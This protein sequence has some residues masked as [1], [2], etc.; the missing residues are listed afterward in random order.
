MTT[1]L[2]ASLYAVKFAGGTPNDFVNSLADATQLPVVMSQ[3]DPKTLAPAEFETSGVDEISRAIRSQLKLLIY[4]GTD[5]VIGDQKLSR[6]LVSENNVQRF[7]GENVQGELTFRVN[8]EESVSGAGGATARAP[9]ASLPINGI[10]LPPTAIKEGKISFKT[11][12]MDAL[13]LNLIGSTLSKPVRT[14]WIYNEA[15]VF[16]NVKDVAEFDLMKL[17]AK[18]VGARLVSNQKEYFF[19]LDPVEIKKRAVATL[20]A[21]ATSSTASRRNNADTQAPAR[22]FRISVINALSPAQLSAALAETGSTAKFDLDSRSPLTR[23]AVQRVQQIDAERQNRPQNGPGG[24]Q[25]AIMSRIDNSRM[26]TL[27]VDSRFGVRM[28]IPILDQNGR[29]GGVVRL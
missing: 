6:N 14:H 18:A 10:P 24:G 17:V 4:P 28:E 25:P 3:G 13:Q 5:L 16:L 26:A 21:E 1:L 11:E 19:D 29:P 9:Q 7:R 8:F 23:L 27:S 12:K 2:I 22:N 15:P 20:Q